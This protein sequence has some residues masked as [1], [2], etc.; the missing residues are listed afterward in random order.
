MKKAAVISILL[1]TLCTNTLCTTLR[2]KQFPTTYVSESNCYN[3]LAEQCNIEELDFFTDFP[4]Y[5]KLLLCNEID[6]IKELTKQNEEKESILKQ[7]IKDNQSQ[8]GTRILAICQEINR[9]IPHLWT[10]WK[11]Q[12]TN[13]ECKKKED[14][15]EIQ[16]LYSQLS[17][18][19]IT[20]KSL[21]ILNEK[22]LIRNRNVPDNEILK[23]EQRERK[24]TISEL[25]QQLSEFEKQELTEDERKIFTIGKEINN[26]NVQICLLDLQAEA[27]RT[28]EYGKLRDAAYIYQETVKYKKKM[29]VERKNKIEILTNENTTIKEYKKIEEDLKDL[30]L[31]ESPLVSNINIDSAEKF[32]EKKVNDLDILEDIL[33]QYKDQYENPSLQGMLE[34]PEIPERQDELDDYRQMIINKMIQSRNQLG[35]LN[36]FIMMPRIDIEYLNEIFI[37]GLQKSEY[38]NSDVKIKKREIITQILNKNFFSNVDSYVESHQAH[39]VDSVYVTVELL[40]QFDITVDTSYQGR[41]IDKERQA[42]GRKQKL[43]LQYYNSLNTYDAKKYLLEIKENLDDLGLIFESL[44]DNKYEIMCREEIERLEIL[45]SENY[46]KIDKILGDELLIYHK[47]IPELFITETHGKN[48]RGVVKIEEYDYVFVRWF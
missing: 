42:Y 45:E 41:F 26:L 13:S 5:L 39:L 12:W 31:L 4:G 22:R 40:K 44:K 25:R 20:Q 1:S 16:A 32:S 15:Q 23:E 33:K 38:L 17:T 9:E 18:G 35:P 46:P 29:S 21:L 6:R 27:A 48:A 7:I 11:R 34:R 24:K 8:N 47:F 3:Q 37:P 28:K 10:N 19:E 43:N 2:T 30:E 14:N 36:I